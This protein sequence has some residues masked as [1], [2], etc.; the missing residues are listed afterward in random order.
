MLIYCRPQSFCE[1]FLDEKALITVGKKLSALGYHTS[2]V[3]YEEK[4][5]ETKRK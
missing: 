4:Q 3:K 2:L 5:K 1:I